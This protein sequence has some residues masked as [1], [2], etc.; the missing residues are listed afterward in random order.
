MA[1]DAKTK[2][3]LINSVQAMKS[4]WL[5][6][7]DYE[8]PETIS[9]ASN[10]EPGLHIAAYNPATDAGDNAYKRGQVIA[11]AAGAGKV[12]TLTQQSESSKN[13]YAI[14]KE[15]GNDEGVYRSWEIADSSKITAMGC[16]AASAG[17]M[18]L[19]N[20][21]LA[22]VDPAT[23]LGSPSGGNGN[24]G[25]GSEKSLDSPEAVGLDGQGRVFIADTGT[26][27]ILRYPK[28]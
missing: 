20:D 4:S 17:T 7:S 19:G 24:T 11:K 5:D 14:S 15:E 18:P 2:S 8:K 3:N 21:L 9:T 12:I 22:N 10:N 26:Q 28:P 25:G 23:F 13:F 1:K 27:R 6:T 16:E